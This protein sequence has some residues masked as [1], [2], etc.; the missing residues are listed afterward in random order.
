MYC[1]KRNGGKKTLFQIWSLSLIKSV[2]FHYDSNCTCTPTSKNIYT[3]KQNRNNFDLYKDWGSY[4][5]TTRNPSSTQNL[6]THQ[7]KLW[8]IKLLSYKFVAI[9]TTREAT[10]SCILS[11]I[12]A[13]CQVSVKHFYITQSFPF[14]FAYL[15]LLKKKKKLI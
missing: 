7:K 3:N 9:E 15:A 4:I 2:S 6:K 12:Y 10:F 5:Q 14:A 13:I 1:T 8:T 11:N